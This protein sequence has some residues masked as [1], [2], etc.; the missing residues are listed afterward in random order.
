MLAAHKC[1]L[2]LWLC[3]FV[4]GGSDLLGSALAQNG[5][6]ADFFVWAADFFA[7]FVADIF[8]LV[9]V[10]KKV[11]RKILQEIPGKILQNLYNKNPR[12]I[13]A[14]GPGQDLPFHIAST[15]ARKHPQSRSFL[16][17]HYST[18]GDTVSCD[19]P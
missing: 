14:E 8:L 17:S 19:A 5:F 13:S 1:G 4:P 11:H 10:W 7:D 12:H 18:I 9:F 3:V 2:L 16:V 15:A 6:F